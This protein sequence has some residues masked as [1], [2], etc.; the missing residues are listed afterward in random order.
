MFPDLHIIIKHSIDT[1][2]N[3]TRQ[4]WIYDKKMT[5]MTQTQQQSDNCE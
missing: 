3:L 2:K 5:Q 4:E 1:V